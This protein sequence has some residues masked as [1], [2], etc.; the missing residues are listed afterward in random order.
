[1]R[2]FLIASGASSIETSAENRH[3]RD[4]IPGKLFFKRGDRYRIEDEK[5]RLP[6]RADLPNQDDAESQK[7]VLLNNDKPL[8]APFHQQVHKK[9]QSGLAAV[10][11]GTDIRNDPVAAMKLQPLNL[12]VQIVFL[13]VRRDSGIT[14]NNTSGRRFLGLL[15]L[16]DFESSVSSERLPSILLSL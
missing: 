11:P 6:S 10:E 13:P 14:D 12:S 8:N 1:M 2:T 15:L 4:D 5:F 3:E 16:T 9:L 7:P